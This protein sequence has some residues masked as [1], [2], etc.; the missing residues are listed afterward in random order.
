MFVDDLHF[1]ASTAGD[2]PELVDLY[3]E[4]YGRLEAEGFPTHAADADTEMI[5]EWQSEATV[6]VATVEETIVGAT[7]IRPER[8]GKLPQIGRI[9]VRRG[10]TRNGIGTELLA[11]AEDRVRERGHDRV[12]LATFTDH[13][14]LP[15]LYESKG[16]EPVRVD[17]TD[18]APYDIL[19]MRKE[20]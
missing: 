3:R 6:R 5:A 19:R 7:R 13:P 1:R 20:L 10:W 14:Y 18:S 11:H 4:A 2:R 8:D 9:A 17:L 16:Y 12:R 15:E